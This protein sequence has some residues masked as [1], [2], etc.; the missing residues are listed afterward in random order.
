MFTIWRF[1]QP[2]KRSAG[3]TWAPSSLRANLSWKI[4]NDTCFSIFLLHKQGKPGIF[5]QYH[6]C[7]NPRKG[8]K[9]VPG[10]TMTTGTEG[11][12]G[13]LKLDC[14][15]K[16]GAQLQF[17]L[18][19]RGIAF[20]FYS[21]QIGVRYNLLTRPEVLML[22]NQI[23][24]YSDTEEKGSEYSQLNITFIQNEHTPLWILPVGVG[25]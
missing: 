15:I 2:K 22:K 18:F 24:C 12:A 16:I 25:P 4:Q 23:N 11:S 17:S 3:P 1:L 21:T 7:R 14:L 13:N 8:A 5:V 20:W 19:S 10:P 9:P 6:T